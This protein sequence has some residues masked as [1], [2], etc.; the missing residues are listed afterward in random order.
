MIRPN[1]HLSGDG[2]HKCAL[3]H[4]LLLQRSTTNEF[5]IKAKNVHSN[6]YSYS[7]TNYINAYTKVIIGCKIH[8]NFL[9]SPTNHLNGQGCPF[10]SKSGFKSDKSASLYV[11]KIRNL[12]NEYTGFGITND[13]ET[14][15]KEHKLNLSKHGFFIEKSKKFNIKIGKYARKIETILKTTLP[16]I[17]IGVDGFRTE[18][19]AMNYHEIIKLVEL[20]FNKLGDSYAS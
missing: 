11:L 12:S 14:R 5:I 19:T 16:I 7:E 15:I 1:N 9:Q 4:S 13:F 6:L 2:C 3:E 17:N 20:E 18:T 10:C 8:G